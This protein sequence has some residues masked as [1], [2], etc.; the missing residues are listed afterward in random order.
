MGD[1]NLEA[2]HAAEHS[3]LE[4]T[5]GK[6]PSIA[7]YDD[8]ISALDPDPLH[9]DQ[10][11]PREFDIPIVVNDEVVKW[12]QYFTG[13]GSRWYRKWL[14]RSTAYQ[15]LM[16]DG[17]D[18]GGLPLDIRYLSMI[19]SGYSRTPTRARR[20]WACGSSSRPRAARTGCRIDSYVDERRDAVGAPP[21]QR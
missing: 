5:A 10:I 18:A 21:R 7:F 6:D 1:P 11:N 14:A 9:L 15:A 20:R 16:A 4:K 13:K 2:E 8:P 3:F 17:L 12:M 19:E